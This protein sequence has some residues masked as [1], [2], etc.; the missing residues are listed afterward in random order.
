MLKSRFV[1][2]KPYQNDGMIMVNTDLISEIRPC[3]EGTSLI[4]FNFLD[5]ENAQE[6]IRIAMNY[7]KV[8]KIISEAGYE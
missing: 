4:Y 7:E 8:C 3:I 5:C 1:H 6:S 2:L